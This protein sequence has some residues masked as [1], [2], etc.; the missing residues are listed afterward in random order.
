MEDT[1]NEILDLE[2]LLFTNIPEDL[3]KKRYNYENRQKKN[4]FKGIQIL[5]RKVT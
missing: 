1:I 3:P 5:K 4:I 2:E